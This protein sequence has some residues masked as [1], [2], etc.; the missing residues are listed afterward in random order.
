MKPLLGAAFKI[1]AL[2]M[3]RGW[4]LERQRDLE[5]QDFTS[6]QSVIDDWLDR[7]RVIKDC[8]SGHTGRLGFHAPFLTLPINAADRDIRSVV[9]RR[10]H[11]ALDVCEYLG[12]NQMVIHSPFNMWNYSNF[13]WKEK[14]QEGHIERIHKTI[15]D[16]VE[17]AKAIG[18][19]LV[20]ENVEDKCPSHRVAVVRSFNSPAIRTSVDT[21]HAHFLHLAG[22]APTCADFIFAAG[23]TLEHVHLQDTDGSG[24]R[25]WHPG[26]GTILWEDVFSAIGEVASK[27]R[28]L[29]EIRDASRFKE[30]V[31]YLVERGLAE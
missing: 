6:S 12:A 4:V 9:N 25:H 31:N 1:E 14:A 3:H 26:R 20:V 30:G 11:Q 7:A 23:E 22:G 2:R 5:I 24:D 19:V 29:L 8:L 16:V 18:C 21:G 27:A 13:Q 17:R 15:G 10:L 28:L